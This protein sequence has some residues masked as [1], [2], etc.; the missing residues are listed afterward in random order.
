MVEFPDGTLRG[1]QIP[2]YEVPPKKK[3]DRK[4]TKYDL[5]KI[6]D[7]VAALK[8]LG[9]TCVTLEAQQP[10]HMRASQGNMA[11]NA[12][13]ASFTTGYGFALWEMAL[14]MAGIDY[15]LAWPS[16]WKKKMGIQAPSEMK[17]QK[18]RERET[19]RLA[20]QE[21][22]AIWPDHDFRRT[23]RCQPSPDQCEAALLVRYGRAKRGG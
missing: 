4:R 2:T 15:I 14:T 19:K 3:G 5:P 12:V 10:T 8:R 23:P 22:Q 11:N 20:V 7:I 6:V 18:A 9:V 1:W 21:A 13:R 16:A 17:D